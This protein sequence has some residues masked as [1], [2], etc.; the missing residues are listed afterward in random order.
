MKRT[1]A[2]IEGLMEDRAAAIGI[3]N[4]YNST[5]NS[6][7]KSLSLFQAKSNTKAIKNV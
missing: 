3:S 6:L 4:D 5:N 1:I 7:H 2:E